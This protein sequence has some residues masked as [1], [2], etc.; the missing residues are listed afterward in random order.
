VVPDE[1]AGTERLTE[2]LILAGGKAERLGDA[3]GGRPKPLVEVGGRPLIAYQVEQLARAGVTRVIV[4]CS[5]GQEDLFERALERLGL[6]VVT[7]PEPERLGRGGG[8]RNAAGLRAEEGPVYALNGD[9]LVDV[10]LRM[11]MERHLER[12]PAATIT[13][14]RPPSPFGLVELDEG[15][16]VTGFDEE[17]T[18]PVWV[19]CG[20][21]VLDDEA[22]ERL[23]E[24]GDHETT[25][26]PELAAE[27]RLQA[28]RHEGLWLTVNTP[29][30][31]RLADEHL[32]KNPNA[33][34]DT[35]RG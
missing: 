26:F 12:R 17:A 29:K 32:R 8:L 14:V 13:V 31:L 24:R 18:L 27:R 10:D 28:F 25:T 21:Y 34:F 5:A 3:A 22:I 2:A 20:V 15:D 19:S 9:E 16:V 11:L 33:V 4:S 1:E 7:A 35:A 6:E 23:P 30:Q